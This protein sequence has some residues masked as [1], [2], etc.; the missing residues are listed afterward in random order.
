[1]TG[2]FVNWKICYLLNFE[3]CLIVVKLFHRLEKLKVLSITKLAE[4][5]SFVMQLAILFLC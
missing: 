4:L 1:M 3:I 2:Y 5:P